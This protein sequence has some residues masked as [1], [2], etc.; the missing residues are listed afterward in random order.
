MSLA[1]WHFL[2]LWMTLVSCPI[3]SEARYPY[4]SEFEYV[5]R[6]HPSRNPDCPSR[7]VDKEKTQE[8]YNR[9]NRPSIEIRA[10]LSRCSKRRVRRGYTEGQG[11]TNCSKK[12]V[13]NMRFNNIGKTETQEKFIVID[14]VLDSSSMKKVPLQSP[15]VIKVRQEAVIHL[16][17]LKFQSVVNAEAREEVIN[18]ESPNYTG[19]NVDSENP[20]CG[21]T[22]MHG[23]P[24]P[25]SQG[26]CCSCDPR[27]NA[28]RQFAGSNESLESSAAKS[29][30]N[31]ANKAGNRLAKQSYTSTSEDPVAVVQKTNNDV[32]SMK[33]S[34][35]RLVN[36]DT[37]ETIGGVS[38][39]AN[40]KDTVHKSMDRFPSMAMRT[41]KEENNHGYLVS[42]KKE[43]SNSRV[44][45]SSE[46]HSGERASL[47]SRPEVSPES[48]PNGDKTASDIAC[49]GAIQ[50]GN[51][52]LKKAGEL[53][54]QQRNYAK[55]V[56][57]ENVNGDR[58]V[59]N[60]RC[61][62]KKDAKNQRGSIENLHS[63]NVDREKHRSNKSTLQKWSNSSL[64]DSKTKWRKKIAANDVKG[65][66]ANKGSSPKKR[67]KAFPVTSTIDSPAA[68][69]LNEP[70]KN[71]STGVLN[72]NG[73]PVS[74]SVRKGNLNG[75]MESTSRR[76]DIRVKS[77]NEKHG[78]NDKKSIRTLEGVDLKLI[79]ETIIDCPKKIR[80]KGSIKNYTPQKRTLK[81]LSYRKNKRH[82]DRR[83]QN[84]VDQSERNFR[85]SNGPFRA[86]RNRRGPT[87]RRKRWSKKLDDKGYAGI[88]NSARGV[89]VYIDNSRPLSR[90]SEQSRSSKLTQKEAKDSLDKRI[91][92]KFSRINDVLKEDLMGKSMDDKSKCTDGSCENKDA[93]SE[94]KGVLSENKDVSS[95]S[96]DVPSENKDAEQKEEAQEETQSDFQNVEDDESKGSNTNLEA[97]N[98]SK[99]EEHVVKSPD[100]FEKSKSSTR[101]A[102]LV[103]SPTN[104]GNKAT[105]DLS[106]AE[107]E[108]FKEAATEMTRALIVVDLF[109]V[110]TSPLNQQL[111]TTTLKPSN[112]SL[113]ASLAKSIQKAFGLQRESETTRQTF[114]ITLN[115][116]TVTE[117][118][119][120][121]TT[122]GGTTRITD[123]ALRPSIR[124]FK[125]KQ[126]SGEFHNEVVIDELTFP[127]ETKESTS[128]TRGDSVTQVQ[129]GR[130][131]KR[132]TP[133]IKDSLGLRSTRFDRSVR[134]DNLGGKMKYSFEVGNVN[135]MKEKLGSSSFVR[136]QRNY[137]QLMV[138]G[139]E[140][141]KSYRK[142]RRLNKDRSPGRREA[143]LNLTGIK[144]IHHPWSTTQSSEFTLKTK[145]HI[146]PK[147]LSRKRVQKESNTSPGRILPPCSKK[148]RRRRLL[149]V[150]TLKS[151]K[152]EQGKGQKKCVDDSEYEDDR[153]KK[154]QL[155]SKKRNAGRPSKRKKNSKNR[156]KKQLKPLEDPMEDYDYR[157]PKD[158]KYEIL[159]E[160]QADDDPE[161]TLENDE[162]IP[163][164]SEKMSDSSELPNPF[165]LPD[166]DVNFDKLPDKMEDS[167]VE[168]LA[169]VEKNELGKDFEISLTGK[170]HLES[171]SNGR[172]VSISFNAAPEYLPKGSARI[173]EYVDRFPSE[174]ASSSFADASDTDNA[175]FLS[176][177]LV[178]PMVPE[179][180]DRFEY[181]D[182]IRERNRNPGRYV[183]RQKLLRLQKKSVDAIKDADQEIRLKRLSQDDDSGFE[184][185]RGSNLKRDVN[186][187]SKEKEV[188]N[189]Q[190]PLTS[191]E[192][193]VVPDSPQVSLDLSNE[194]EASFLNNE[195][196]DVSTDVVENFS[197]ACYANSTTA[198]ID[199]TEE[200]TMTEKLP[201]LTNQT[202][203]SYQD[204]NIPKD[205]GPSV[206]SA[207]FLNVT[208]A[209]S[210]EDVTEE[211]LPTEKEGY[212]QAK[213]YNA[214]QEDKESA[215][216]KNMLAVEEFVKKLEKL[217]SD[218]NS[219]N[220]TGNTLIH[221]KKYII[222]PSNQ[223]FW[224]LGKLSEA[225][226]SQPS[227]DT[228]V[229]MG[230]GRKE[231]E[232]SED[233]KSEL[234]DPD[235]IREIIS[236]VI[237]GENRDA[238]GKSIES[239]EQ[240]D[241]IPN[242]EIQDVIDE[243]LET[244][245]SESLAKLRE[246]SKTDDQFLEKNSENVKKPSKNGNYVCREGKS[247][248]KEKRE[249]GNLIRRERKQEA[250]NKKKD[251]RHEKKKHR[252]K[253]KRKP[254]KK[255]KNTSKKGS[256]KS[257]WPFKRNLL[258][259]SDEEQVQTPDCG[260][261]WRIIDKFSLC[262]KSKSKME[263]MKAP[264]GGNKFREPQIRGGQDCSD[265][266]HPSKY[267]ESAHCLRFSNLWYSV[268]QLEEPVVS[269][270]IH[271]QI[272]AKRASVDESIFWQ[273][274]TNG[275]SI[276]LGT[277]DK[278]YRD[279][280]NTM[281]FTYND[282]QLAPNTGHSLDPSKDRLL[283]PSTLSDRKYPDE[284]W[285]GEYLVVQA[286]KINEDANECDKAGVGFTAFVNQPD[287]CERVRGTCLKNQPMDYWRHDVEARDS[288]RSGCYFL[289]N[290]AWVPSEAIKYNVNGT[291][292]REFLALEYHSPHVSVI[293]VELGA[294]YNALLRAGS[295]GRLTEVYI[296]NTAIDYTVITVL[297]TN[298]GS[299][300]SS[301]RV[302]ITDCPQGLPISWLNAETPTK[303]ISSHRDRKVALD[304]YGRLSL[305]EFSCSV[306]LLNSDGEAV[307][308]RR[309]K[310]RR[311]NRCFCIR[312]CECTCGRD[313][314]C[315]P[316]SLK[317]YHAAG[318]RGPLPTVPDESF[319]WFHP[320]TV[321]CLVFI[322]LLLLLLALGILKWAIGMCVPAVS[323]WGLDALLESDKMEEYYEKD[324][325]S[326][327]VVFN[328]FGQP[329][330]PDTRR[331]SVR[332]CKRKVE[333]FL[334]LI[335]FF[336]HPL[337][338]CC[339]CTKPRPSKS[340][341]VESK[342]SLMSE[343]DETPTMICLST[344]G[345]SINSKMEAEDTKECR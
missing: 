20:T 178:Q 261:K 295:Y 59:P 291:G 65:E 324:L 13:I 177:S 300:S 49:D 171:D 308:N 39:S 342:T 247:N 47:V 181:S 277:F 224:G 63:E 1:L 156:S 38:G 208:A 246:E 67:N 45:D 50:P 187:V 216:K 232:E 263:R 162:T 104:D 129:D 132:M 299:S 147:G 204:I 172:P 237:S 225:E 202:V 251:A 226:E 94:S 223:T 144:C 69:H 221:L 42:G 213:G 195:P 330:H 255:K 325:K 83:N 137:L 239:K 182:E 2:I 175:N 28:R 304:L 280:A 102:E 267:L 285:S 74:Q 207:Q 155:K 193:N 260:K 201:A 86:G 252:R 100:E 159:D 154:S 26:F 19:C 105:S 82:R 343:K 282:I 52:S 6:L 116:S 29:N 36:S 108:L 281:D 302:R 88:Q 122:T 264:D 180:A 328:E 240:S 303:T 120:E 80:A 315:R 106:L 227:V 92:E 191:E 186:V 289:S 192:L 124:P 279:K 54:K 101:N 265:R 298:K 23:E 150:Q 185:N 238:S 188:K 118:S 7:F 34:N 33:K 331:K 76:P 165:Q 43:A 125:A 248:L 276:R 241:Q 25:F 179:A 48:P 275:S 57:K 305:N 167:K 234:K 131:K 95:E 242:D 283:V 10:V 152:N 344:Y 107:E 126:T 194:P 190:E 99:D 249:A 15:Y 153:P 287:R 311:N 176:N 55:M 133:S 189:V 119:T 250:R 173:N 140:A 51:V 11:I 327:S 256:K 243:K 71:L 333:F 163:S 269:H 334:N 198:I 115:E 338:C 307:A 35:T 318:F 72:S 184:G 286:D 117:N 9:W 146:L 230:D 91:D 235:L 139:Q 85:R 314:T 168:D 290:F 340:I 345:D 37:A 284:G 93:A 313:R 73:S 149:S 84:E 301:Y 217:A 151:C 268:Y 228:K 128:A 233:E 110:V 62:V 293:D 142:G 212:G 244:G 220:Q 75:V 231:A 196:E 229:I 98:S 113:M 258:M 336:I 158:R 109:K 309:L 31:V 17:G 278:R 12:I 214:T 145:D 78:P 60:A 205:T 8:D 170:I 103:I 135:L 209:D 61:S 335:F 123:Q 112:R 138:N 292:S 157:M 199:V 121:A 245:K 257:K 206:G 218:G 211:A 319:N 53:A 310:A 332:I 254:K 66:P 77:F 169:Q 306:E 16:Y 68:M 312:H 40:R 18:N 14:H 141:E 166:T 44:T 161:E 274:L 316:V 200:T 317:N 130:K 323:R 160:R 79:S 111:Q 136:E 58:S 3:M 294:D 56:D 27:T 222:V 97:E 81:N 326:R 219:S 22:F 114:V 197:G 273:D 322:G 90:T 89:Q 270:K 30:Y 134:D 271:L 329:V 96:K 70:L 148:Y 46:K 21:L 87:S 215:E 32:R 64:K 236:S 174:S 288:G 253:R 266:R 259:L 341:P 272:Y 321:V 127:E 210:Y 320:V 339:Y 24:V 262:E 5:P 164:E 183:G 297:I 203:L 4:V 337:V 296:D 41:N 143:S